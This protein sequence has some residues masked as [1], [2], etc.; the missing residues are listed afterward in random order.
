MQLNCSYRLFYTL[1]LWPAG[2]LPLCKVNAKTRLLLVEFTT[3]AA[4]L[5]RHQNEYLLKNYNE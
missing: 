1:I 3:F 4:L 5:G 2:I